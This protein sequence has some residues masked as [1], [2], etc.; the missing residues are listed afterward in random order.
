[1]PIY[2]DESGGISTGA[3][4]LAAVHI[5]ADAADA[6]VQRFKD[7]TNLRGELKG[8]RIGLSERGLFFELLERFG[9]KALVGTALR[10]NLPDAK[11]GER[12]KDLSAYIM[13]LDQVIASLLPETG[14]CAHVVIDDGRYDPKIQNMVRQDIGEMLGTCGRARLADSK[15]SVGVQIADVIANSAFNLAVNSQR[16]GRIRRI[17]KPHFESHILRAMSV[18][19]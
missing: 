3:M 11:P 18:R 13:L 9:G 2:C 1:M 14:G 8:S 10:E 7:I 12:S 17:T 4:T 15:K 6:L 5:D 16:A 19:P